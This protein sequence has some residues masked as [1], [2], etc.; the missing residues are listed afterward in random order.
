MIIIILI[1]I[2][3][4][5]TIT[6]TITTTTTSWFPMTNFHDKSKKKKICEDYE[7]DWRGGISGIK[8][9]LYCI[10]FPNRNV[11]GKSKPDR[12]DVDDLT[13]LIV[14][15]LKYVVKMKERNKSG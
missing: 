2:I 10:R 9:L 14:L 4:I 6:I 13:N 11:N 1:I 15:A 5:I 8:T 3:I 7:S 12:V